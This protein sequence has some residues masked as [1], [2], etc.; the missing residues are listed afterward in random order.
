MFW[1]GVCTEPADSFFAQTFILHP[2][3]KTFFAF[4]VALLF[5]STTALAQKPIPSAKVKSLD[6]REFDTKNISNEEGPIIISFWATWCSPCKRELNTIAEDWEDWVDETGVKLVAV[7]IDDARNMAKVKPY[8]DGKGWEYDV[9]LDP[10]GDFKRALG[11]N[12][13]PHTFLAD[14]K[15]NI[16]WQHSGYSPG[17]E[18]ELRELV[19]KVAEGQPI[20]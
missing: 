17:D 1:C 16:V 5:V 9:L 13:V 6:G 10:N 15:G 8:V 19:E 3:M 11:V 4:F 20:K 18:E 14:A 7:S 12:N 2:Y